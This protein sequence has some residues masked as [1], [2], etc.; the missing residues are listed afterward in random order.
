MNDLAEKALHAL[1]VAQAEVRS[2][3]VISLALSGFVTSSVIVVA[4]SRAAA[5]R[6]IE[7]ISSWLGLLHSSGS[8]RIDTAAG[9]V[10]LVGITT[11]SLLWIAAVC[12]LR[13]PHHPE[14][15]AWTIGAAWA[16]PFVIGPPLMDTH[17]YL[18]VA[19]GLLQRA[20]HDPYS[21]SINQLG[22]API[23][24]SI[25]PSLRGETSG[26]GPLATMIQHLSVAASG[27]HPLGAVILFRA[28]AVVA[29]IALGRSAVDLAGTRRTEVLVLTVLNP[30][31]LLYG[32][33]AAHMDVIVAA[34]LV[35]A[36]VAV[37]QRRWIRGIVLAALAG[38]ML[39]VALIAIPVIVAVH[40][41]GRRGGSGW[42][43]AGRDLGEAA[44]V[45]VLISL[46]VDN[47]FGWISTAS[48]QFPD[49]TPFA[50]ANVVGKMLRPFVPGASFDDL[51]AGGRLTAI[52]A[53]ACIVVYLLVSAR[54][55]PVDLTVGYALLA[56]ALL[57]P[58]VHPWFFIWPVACLAP[59]AIGVRR[60]IL[61]VI[62]VTA[63][64]L[65]VPGFTDAVA[66]RVAIAAIAIGAVVLAL[67]MWRGRE[68]RSHAPIRSSAG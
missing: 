10:T 66:V 40:V 65:V 44:A 63:A 43:V 54:Y 38:S 24:S 53:I 3:P 60:T 51:A 59:S 32:I 28:A 16:L 21:G 14:S 48:D 61:V 35:A 36:L 56:M 25:D 5:A 15:R 39:P 34:L 41:C 52:I 6:A 1:N 64:L 4:G 31:V 22:G 23:V 29:V 55:R 12:T 9:V 17:V 18:D 19:R 8:S 58:D 46:V 13:S 68:P 26:A 50:P 57:A 27:G 67:L 11:L 33:S 37:N 45:I 20:G 42:L 49:Y 7:P 62:S 30:L 2:R 47:G